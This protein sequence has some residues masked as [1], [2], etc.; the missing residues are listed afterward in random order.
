[1][2]VPGV[3]VVEFPDS[4]DD[5]A[6]SAA[7]KGMMPTARADGGVI[8]P[9]SQP[10]VPTSADYEY[11]P[12]PGT[13]ILSSHPLN[14]AQQQE[15]S[16]TGAVAGVPGVSIRQ[17]GAARQPPARPGRRPEIQT[18][19]DFAESADE[20]FKRG[21]LGTSQAAQAVTAP[22]GLLNGLLEAVRASGGDPVRMASN[23]VMAEGGAALDRAG[24]SY[25]Q[26]PSAEAGTGARLLARLQ[27]VLAAAPVVGE[28][29][30]PARRAI[31]ADPRAPVD[32]AGLVGAVTGTGVDAAL[33]RF[34]PGAAGRAVAPAANAASRYAT[35]RAT[36][37]VNAAIGATP[38]AYAGGR[39]PAAAAMEEGITGRTPAPEAATRLRS[40]LDKLTAEKAKLV[41]DA[42]AAGVVVTT[43]PDVAK[44]V[45][46]AFL[47][48]MKAATDTFGAKSRQVARYKNLHDNLLNKASTHSTYSASDMLTL[49]KQVDD[50]AAELPKK[51]PVR[52]ALF[53]LRRDL[54]TM[55]DKGVQGMGDVNTRIRNRAS[56]RE[57]ADAQTLRD[58]ARQNRGLTSDQILKW[59]LAGTAGGA[60]TAIGY[61]ALRD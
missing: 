60:G 6:I 53:T 26:E 28:M 40:S 52:R 19:P 2:E 34:L 54:D 21:A 38:R 48:R 11:E 20:R 3:G 22:G 42:D 5:A 36:S 59:L 29:V 18:I 35:R 37:R 1:M 17:G 57:S 9:P 58:A 4:M 51:S 44:L 14:S 24:Q 41:S 27:T 12:V 39:N 56:A 32:V 10:G 16:M 46:N 50:M 30:E 33:A 47:D 31:P 13:V 55:F 15:A 43:G 25:A 23:A 49:I 8:P 45:N 7:I 61:N